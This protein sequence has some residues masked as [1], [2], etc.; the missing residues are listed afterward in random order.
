M[1]ARATHAL[2]SVSP[3]PTMPSSVIT[4]TTIVSC[5]ELVA[6]ASYPGSSRTCVL[7][8]TTCTGSDPA[9]GAVDRDVRAGEEPG[10][11]GAEEHARVGDL[12]DAAE[13]ADRML[14]EE[15]CLHLRPALHRIHHRAVQLR[16]D[17]AGH[18][19]VRADR[20]RAVLDGDV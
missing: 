4:S 16:L 17:H 15:V 13:A 19:R 7:T 8:S 10:L 12:L 18:Q 20:A 5:A 11:G 9:V 6:P 1:K 14:D 3:I 2:R